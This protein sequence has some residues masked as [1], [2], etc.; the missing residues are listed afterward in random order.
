MKRVV[1]ALLAGF[2]LV[3]ASPAAAESGAGELPTVTGSDCVPDSPRTVTDLPWAQQWLMP[4]AAW[5]LT[6]GKG[7]TVAVVDGGVGSP[8]SLRQGAVKNPGKDCTGHGTLLASLV[9]GRKAGLV[10]FSGVAPAA[11]ILSVKVTTSSPGSGPPMAT[12]STL[13][14]A[15]RSAVSGG[16]KVVLLGAVSTTPSKTLADAVKAAVR[17]NVL[18]VAGVG[19]VSGSGSKLAE[20]YPS[21]YPGVVGVAAMQMTGE[22]ASF[23]AYSDDVDVMAPGVGVVG[24]A[25]SGSGHYVTDGTAVAAAFVAGTAAL[26]RSYR[27]DLDVAA[28][29]ERLEL[30][31]APSPAKGRHAAMGFGVVDPAAAVA[32][33]L[34]PTAGKTDAPA[35]VVRASADRPTLPDRDADLIALV[36]AVA[37]LGV[38]AVAGFVA[39]IVRRG[40][41][42]RW[43][44]P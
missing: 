28:V 36:V 29:T 27:P 34:P 3:G 16:A 19:T 44:A 13:A 21:A 6:R 11:T 40:R 24:A 20:S 9:A 33:E 30:T 5:T 38:A 43:R 37:G 35:M 32:Y 39:L 22:V 12:P 42:R 2:V 7:V 31:A 17:A 8:A 18:I 41:A 25:P 26:V 23:S 1:A 10:A 15:I 14:G 4:S